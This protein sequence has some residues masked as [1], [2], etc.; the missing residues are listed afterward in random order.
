MKLLFKW[1]KGKHRRTVR[2][3]K[4]KKPSLNLF[5]LDCYSTVTGSIS[6]SLTLIYF[7]S[8]GTQEHSWSRLQNKQTMMNINYGLFFSFRNISDRNREEYDLK[9]HQGQNIW[10]GSRYRL[11]VG[12]NKPRIL[13]FSRRRQNRLNGVLGETRTARTRVWAS[14]AHAS[15][16]KFTSGSRRSLSRPRILRSLFSGRRNAFK[17][18]SNFGIIRPT[19]LT[20]R[21]P[22]TNIWNC[23]LILLWNGFI[24]LTL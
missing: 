20:Y 9:K 24:Y 19:S 22:D 7:S 12:E 10:K 18:N 6:T 2:R 4:S 21:L 1:A 17:L 3:Y 14:C 13:T 5:L 15:L 23:L 16:C 11:I 8:L